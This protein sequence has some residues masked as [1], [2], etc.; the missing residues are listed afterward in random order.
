MPVLLVVPSTCTS[1]LQLAP[2]HG[3]CAFV[4]A[5]LW[6]SPTYQHVAPYPTPPALITGSSPRWGVHNAM[7]SLLPA[8]TTGATS[9][10][11]DVH[12]HA[13][14]TV[15]HCFKPLLH[16]RIVTSRLL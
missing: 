4:A 8:V 2:P 7:D 5:D 11:G 16:A 13:C 1:A 6:M 9:N 14:V 12:T 15:S 10:P 3:S